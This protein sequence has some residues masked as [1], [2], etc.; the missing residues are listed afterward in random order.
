M[1]K[2]WEIPRSSSYP[3]DLETLP[4]LLTASQAQVPR[5]RHLSKGA[6]A[7]GK[8]WFT[9]RKCSRELF[10]MSVHISCP[11]EGLALRRSSHLSFLDKCG[12]EKKLPANAAFS[13]PSSWG[14]ETQTVPLWGSPTACGLAYST[15]DQGTPRTSL[16]NRL[17]SLWLRDFMIYDLVTNK[18]G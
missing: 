12:K 11:P 8:W 4:C 18:T 2:F 16:A 1:G 9:E 15:F 7:P 3:S 13:Q 5:L 6:P 17:S 14:P 10:P